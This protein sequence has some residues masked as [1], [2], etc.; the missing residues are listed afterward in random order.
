MP[1][2]AD[3]MGL[4]GGGEVSVG[5]GMECVRQ[6]SVLIDSDRAIV[7]G[8]AYCLSTYL[9]CTCLPVA[10]APGAAS[11]EMED[12]VK[13]G[14]CKATASINQYERFDTIGNKLSTYTASWTAARPSANT[15][16]LSH[17]CEIVVRQSIVQCTSLSLVTIEVVSHE[18]RAP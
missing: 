8:V 4:D 12:L 2:G 14:C 10:M 13:E 15:S 7:A 1:V 3:V 5:S 17:R 6:E 18:P 11:L 9:R 16:C